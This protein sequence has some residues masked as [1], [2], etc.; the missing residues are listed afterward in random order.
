[1]AKRNHYIYIMTNKKD[2]VL[3]IGM[4]NDLRRR[5]EEHKQGV[6]SAFVKRYNL[7]YL[8]YYEVF[9]DPENAIKREKQLKAGSRKK[10]VALVEERN[11]EWNDLYGEFTQFT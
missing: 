9:T 2:G 1:M 6:G 5:M 10:K 3:Y 4:T 11:P 7:H 8:V